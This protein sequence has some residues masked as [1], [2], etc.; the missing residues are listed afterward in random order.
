MTFGRRRIPD[1]VGT[2]LHFHGHHRGHRFDAIDIH[3]RQLFDECQH[4]I[5]LALQMRNLCLSDRDPREMR[6]TANGGGID[7]HYI[8]PLMGKLSP[9]YSRGGFCAATAGGPCVSRRMGLFSVF[10]HKDLAPFPLGEGWGERLRPLATWEPEAT[11]KNPDLCPALDRSR[12]QWPK[13]GSLITDEAARLFGEGYG[14]LNIRIRTSVLAVLFVGR[15]ARK[16]KH[17]Q[18]D[19][20]L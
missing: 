6:D 2:L 15:E 5:Q 16:A 14:L 17:R 19:V 7:G 13:K 10:R 3:F 9:P 11:R 8:G 1:H 12:K 18:G 20:T 4:G